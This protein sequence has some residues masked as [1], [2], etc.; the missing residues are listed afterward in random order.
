VSPSNWAFGVG[1]NM[2]CEGGFVY[3][4]IIKIRHMIKVDFTVSDLDGKVIKTYSLDL[5]PSMVLIEIDNAREV[6]DEYHVRAKSDNPIAPFEV[7]KIKTYKQEMMER[8]HMLD[9]HDEC[10]GEDW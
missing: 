1:G 5:E 9:M 8:Q 10:C 7:F 2:R 4:G 3:C 6:W